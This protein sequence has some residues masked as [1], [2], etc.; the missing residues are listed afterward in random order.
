[1]WLMIHLVHITVRQLCA[2]EEDQIIGYTD[3]IQLFFE[4]A[5]FCD[6]IARF[7]IWLI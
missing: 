7:I 3:L 6:E 2:G 1:M 4:A 5:S